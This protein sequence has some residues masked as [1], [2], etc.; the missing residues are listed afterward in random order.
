MA[1]SK[2]L[3]ELIEAVIADGEIT[4]KERI[5]LKKRAAKEGIDAEEIEVM[6]EN[7]LDDIRKRQARATN[8]PVC[9][10]EIPYGVSI[11]PKCGWQRNTSVDIAASNFIQD[12]S[13]GL[14]IA[15]QQER[16]SKFTLNY[17]LPNSKT[18]LIEF[19][20]FLKA[21]SFHKGYGLYSEHDANYKKYKECIDKLK[22]LYPNDPQAN[23]IVDNYKRLMKYDSDKSFNENLSKFDFFFGSIIVFGIS[24]VIGIVVSN[25]IGDWGGTSFLV[26]FILIMFGYYYYDKAQVAKNTRPLENLDELL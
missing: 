16:G 24:I 13:K 9:Q 6:V 12:Y 8:C 3:E 20:M 22:M 21:K 17:P 7:R 5:A 18:D 4:L 15:E 23:Q 26:S 11:C 19:A 1:F 14:A 25:I 10:E 2:E